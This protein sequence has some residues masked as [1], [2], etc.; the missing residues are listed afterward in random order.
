MFL[1]STLTMITLLLNVVK[2]DNFETVP[3]ADMHATN[4]NN[5]MPN[6]VSGMQKYLELNGNMKH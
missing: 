2:V 3:F 6:K 4:N 1:I 5:I